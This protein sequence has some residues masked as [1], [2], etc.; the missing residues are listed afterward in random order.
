MTNQS[1]TRSLSNSGGHVSESRLVQLVKQDNIVL[2]SVNNPPVNTINAA[3]RRDLNAALDE[4]A[5]LQGVQAVVLAC[6]GSTFF[7]GA[8]IGEFSGL[9]QEEAYR[10]LFGLSLIHI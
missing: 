1:K 6:E 10:T 9:P 3:V 4:L 5:T 2:L 8:D 7:S